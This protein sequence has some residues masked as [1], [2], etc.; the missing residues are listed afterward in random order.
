[1][2]NEKNP[3]SATVA[4]LQGEGDVESAGRQTDAA[5][6]HANAGLYPEN[7]SANGRATIHNLARWERQKSSTR[8]R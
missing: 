6:R 1:M 5:Y 3:Y 8:K 7:Q 2:A 4:F